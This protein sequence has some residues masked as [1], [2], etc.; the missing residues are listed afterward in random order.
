MIGRTAVVA[1]SLLCAVLFCAIGAQSASAAPTESIKTTAFTCKK[2]LKT[3]FQFEDADCTRESAGGKSGLY[4]HVEI[5]LSVKT[6]IQASKAGVFG[7]KLTGEAFGVKVEVEC[8]KAETTPAT[9]VNSEAEKK[10]KVS[11]E[12]TIAL[13]GSCTVIKPAN[14][15]VKE[16]IKAVTTYRGVEG[17]VA[18]G[19]SKEMGVEFKPKEGTIFTTLEFGSKEGKLCLLPAKAEVTGTATA[20]G[21]G[22]F[23]IPSYS[24]S[25]LEFS[26]PM[27]EETL[28]FA[29]NPASFTLEST[30]KM[31]ENGNPVALTT[32]T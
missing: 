8:G 19:G 7:P 2:E 14:C 29:G 30:V 13:S 18:K 24:G 10:H 15:T 32:V 25:I 22:H 6:G 26:K 4:A 5:G 1:L 20:T 12:A 16:P 23:E 9:V 27:T 17:E 3:D 31:T 21:V 28:K 11:G